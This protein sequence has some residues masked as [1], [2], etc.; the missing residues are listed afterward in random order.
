MGKKEIEY[1]SYGMTS[2]TY[3][4]KHI[5]M[6]DIDRNIE[7]KDLLKIINDLFELWD[8]THIHLIGSTNGYNLISLDKTSLELIHTI[9]RETEHIDQQFNEY[10]YGRKYYTLRIGEDKKYITCFTNNN[11]KNFDPERSNGH[12]VLLNNLYNIRIP[13]D[14]LFDDYEQFE[15]VR[16]TDIKER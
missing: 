7:D 15:L 2:K 10:N 4:D 6:G 16:Y 14:P 9:N 12:R 8:L 13:K 5:Y 11:H 1:I 3:D